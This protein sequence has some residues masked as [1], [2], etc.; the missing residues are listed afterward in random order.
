MNALWI[1]YKQNPCTMY[2]HGPE[3][4]DINIEKRFIFFGTYVL[5]FFN[6]DVSVSKFYT[7]IVHEFYTHRS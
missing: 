4:T 6:V 1:L 5:S 2:V 3:N 7:Y